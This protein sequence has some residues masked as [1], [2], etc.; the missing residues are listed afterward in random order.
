MTESHDNIRSERQEV[1]NALIGLQAALDQGDVDRAQ[2][3]AQV[4]REQ[5]YDLNEA[6][7]HAMRDGG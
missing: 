4:L 1:E 6:T 5:L 7:E 3:M 2:V